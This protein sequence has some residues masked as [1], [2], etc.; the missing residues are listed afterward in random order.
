MDNKRNF[1][2]EFKDLWHENKGKIKV[3]AICLLVGGVYG[4]AKGVDT[5][6]KLMRESINRLID[7]MPKIPDIS[8]EDA[9]NS[10]PK[11]VFLRCIDQLD[12]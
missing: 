5:Q 11:E 1:K 4:F 10:I 12:I 9:L 8:Y 6:G 7:K 3:G 2:Q